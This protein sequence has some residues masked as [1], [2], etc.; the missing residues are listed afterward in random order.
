MFFLEKNIITKDQFFAARK[1]VLDNIELLLEDISYGENK[2]KQI[3]Y[4]IPQTKFSNF[5]VLTDT[6]ISPKIFSTLKKKFKKCFLINL[7]YGNIN[8]YS[9]RAHKDGQSYQF[10]GKRAYEINQ[11]I[12]K[13]IHYFNDYEPHLLL[14]T[15]SSKPINFFENEKIFKMINRYYEKYIK[16]NFFY[17][18]VGV[19][20]CDALIMDNN[21]W[22]KTLKNTKIN[23]QLIKGS[24]DMK[25]IFT[26]YDVVVDDKEIAKEYAHFLSEKYNLKTNY[27]KDLDFLQN[28]KLKLF[29][30]VIDVS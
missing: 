9:I 10:K 22:H 8:S 25:K 6:I 16:Q 30:E 3:T 27:K 29:D 12:F 2:K 20:N 14:S 28:T 13:V 11:K 18:N 26:S 19:K 21:T 15:L 5:K 24:Y 17:K 1:N 23:D 7:F 4:R